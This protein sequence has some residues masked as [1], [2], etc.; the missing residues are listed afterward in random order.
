MSANNDFFLMK[1]LLKHRIPGMVEGMVHRKNAK[2][3]SAD[4][5]KMGAVI[6]QG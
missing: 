5:G 2:G 6:A 3:T 1:K 4:A